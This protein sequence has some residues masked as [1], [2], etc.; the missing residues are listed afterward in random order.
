MTL[1][2]VIHREMLPIGLLILNIFWLL[3]FS[4]KNFE[5]SVEKFMSIYKYTSIF[6][7]KHINILYHRLGNRTRKFT[8][9][10][11]WENHFICGTIN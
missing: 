1:T 10:I 9:Q 8:E 2:V 11:L 3:L 7:N 4:L 6:L 5:L